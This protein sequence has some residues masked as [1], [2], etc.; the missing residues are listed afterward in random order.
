[1]EQRWQNS[2]ELDQR[3]VEGYYASV[4]SQ[5]LVGRS[6]LFRIP[7]LIYILHPLKIFK[8]RGP[9]GTRPN[10]RNEFVKLGRVARARDLAECDDR[11]QCTPLQ[12]CSTFK[13]L[14]YRVLRDRCPFHRLL[15]EW[16]DFIKPLRNRSWSKLR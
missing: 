15:Q 4:A 7:E 6:T 1:M 8:F 16:S 12:L 9:L 5:Q 3:F 2:R 11:S 13:V 10:L 14:F